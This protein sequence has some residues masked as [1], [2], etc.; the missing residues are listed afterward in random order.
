MHFSPIPLLRNTGFALTLAAGFVAQAQAADPTPPKPL[1]MLE[2]RRATGPLQID[3]LGT[4]PAWKQAATI[5]HFAPHWKGTPAHSQTTAKLLWDDQ[6]LYF[7]ADMQDHDLYA[8]VTE[9]D[10]EAWTNDVFELFFKPSRDL[11]GYYEFEVNA[12]N[13]HMEM[14]LPSRG[15]GGYRRWA[16]ARKFGWTTAVRLRGELNSAD[17]Q[18]PA[19]EGWSVEGRIPWSDFAPTR[20]R[21]EI[22]AV[23]W[24]ALCRYDFSKE[25]EAPEL[26]S[27]APLRQSNFHLYEDYGE[28]RFV[29][30]PAQ[31]K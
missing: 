3:G 27:S 16:R 21:P 12:A 23:W 5:R 22:G 17:T 18:A 28:L 7:F 20:G 13:T 14:Y 6:Y 2:C 4:D 8:D 31:S 15:S 24:C 25:L 11:R 30:A 9:Q 26:T 29:A 10:G 1:P 19:A